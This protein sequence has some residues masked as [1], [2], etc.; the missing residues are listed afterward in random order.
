[1]TCEVVPH[2]GVGLQVPDGE[3]FH[4]LGDYLCVLGDSIYSNLSL[5]LLVISLS[6]ESRGSFIYFRR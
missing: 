5:F 3:S 6:F 1:M 2:C 4:V